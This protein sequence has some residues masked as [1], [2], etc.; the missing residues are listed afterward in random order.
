M[1][2]FF[3]SLRITGEIEPLEKVAQAME[4]LPFEFRR[5]GE[6]YSRRKRPQPINILL[7]DLAKWKRRG[8]FLEEYEET[9]Q[10]VKREENAQFAAATATLQRLVPVL[11]GLDR[12]RCEPE[13]YVSTIR[14]EDNGGFGF[15]AEFVSA[16]GAAGLPIGISILVM[17]EDDDSDD[18]ATES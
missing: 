17:L 11:A 1:S 14:E 6:M 4:G 18:A 3:I 15:P 8:I 12:R 10:E 2:R 7:L 13:I 5:R 16:A 9:S